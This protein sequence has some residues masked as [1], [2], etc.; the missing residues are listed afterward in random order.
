MS[1]FC[2]AWLRDLALIVR[3]WKTV[4]TTLLLGG[5]QVPLSEAVAVYGFVRLKSILRSAEIIEHCVQSWHPGKVTSVYA[6]YPGEFSF[7]CDPRS[8]GK[9]NR[10]I[11]KLGPVVSSFWLPNFC[12]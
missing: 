10:P 6:Q 2:R 12:I 9:G 3:V 7:H 1:S 11:L 8:D 5:L 4:A